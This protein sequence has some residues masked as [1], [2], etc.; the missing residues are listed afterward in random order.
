MGVEG[1]RLGRTNRKAEKMVPLNHRFEMER[2]VRSDRFRRPSGIWAATDRDD[3]EAYLLWLI[4]KTGSAVDRDVARL[5]GETVRRVRGV[6]ARQSA[7]EVLLEVID[8][9]EDDQEIGIRMAGADGPFDTLSPGG[10][11]R[12]KTVPA[13]CADGL[14]FGAS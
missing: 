13:H 6:L 7:R 11:A 3:G 4:E 14:L 8:I 12:S 1:S 2:G 10:A 5:L 9:V